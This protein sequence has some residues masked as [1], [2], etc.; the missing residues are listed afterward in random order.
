MG[1]L[2]AMDGMDVQCFANE[3]EGDVMSDILP[4]MRSEKHTRQ[5][6]HQ[7]DDAGQGPIST[8]NVAAAIG[9]TGCLLTFPT[10]AEL[11]HPMS[12]KSG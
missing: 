10:T 6:K 7:N 12:G 2:G 9:D 5:S 11:P 4:S 3:L 1:E 8:T